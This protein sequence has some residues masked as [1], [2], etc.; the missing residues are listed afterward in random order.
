M[1]LG[2]VALGCLCLLAVVSAEVL[3]E[4]KFDAGWDKR[5][6]KSSWK[7]SDGS[8][9]KFTWTA[10]K[11]YGDEEA[12]KGIQTGPDSKY[13]ALYS[14]LKKAYTNEDKELIVQ[15]S[16][17]HEQDLD[18][19]GGY[20]KLLPASSGKKMKDFGGE[21]PYS[22]MFGPDICGY[23]TRKTHVILTYD[24]KN[25]L[26][27]KDIKAET[28]QLTHVYTLRLMPNNTYEVYVDLKQVESGSLYDDFDM[29]APK[30]I[31]DPKATKPEDWDEREKIADPED[32]KPDGWD[33]IPA[34]IVDP[35]AKK[36]EDWS[37]EDDGEWE[38]PTIP[39]PEYKGEWKPK[40]IDNPAYKGIWV[41]P[42]ID[43]PEYK[44]DDKL[45]LQKDIKYVGFELWQVKSGT[46]FDN[47][48]VTNSLEEAKKFAEDTWGK[49]KDGEK[50][51][52][53]KI[54]EEKK[55]EEDAKKTDDDA[56]KGGDDD[57]DEYD[58]ED[59][60]DKK[61]APKA[62]LE[63]KAEDEDEKDEL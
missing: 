54:K 11:W 44:H 28:D 25:H 52:H 9:G 8:A 15:F 12:D 20:I 58:T 56:K 51:M 45:Y 16:A 24:G 35:D 7:E 17:K 36:P 55:K 60:D 50:E 10:G 19:G 38:A 6:Q 41:A 27:K 4:E 5:W 40:M 26:V 49:T 34:T 42:D 22:V 59:G 32:K 43:N 23:S 53:D 47:I 61:E 30:T 62:T 37:D 63:D 31:K 2:A 57:D 21:T 18:C 29:L 13:F 14:E 3:F 1:K 39:N 46:I 33:D 48:L